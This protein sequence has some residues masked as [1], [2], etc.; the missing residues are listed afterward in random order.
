MI[1]SNRIDC[2]NNILKLIFKWKRCFRLII[3]LTEWKY[4]SGLLEIVICSVWNTFLMGL[5]IMGREFYFHGIIRI[6]CFVGCSCVCEI[7]FTKEVCSCTV[8][9]Y[10][11][12]VFFVFLLGL[13]LLLDWWC[14]CRDNS[15]FT[16]ERRSF[17]LICVLFVNNALDKSLLLKLDRF[18]LSTMIRSFLIGNPRALHKLLNGRLTLFKPTRIFLLK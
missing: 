8:L 4:L 2:I 1:L 14:I 16:L 9:K 6:C 12:C 3:V 15:N 7:L 10:Y 17:S 11:L 18:V 13:L 5:L